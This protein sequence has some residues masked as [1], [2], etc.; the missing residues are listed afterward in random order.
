MRALPQ[1]YMLSSQRLAYERELLGTL[2][3]FRLEDSYFD[4]AEQF[5]AVGRLI[6]VAPRSGKREAFRV[7]LEYPRNFPGLPQ[8]VYD[9]DKRF[10]MGQ[11]GHLFDGHMLCLTLPERNE[12]SLGS[13]T[14]TEEVLGAA[15]IWFHKRSIF[16]R[17]KKWPGPAERHGRLAK[18][19]FL[20]EAAGLQDNPQALA[21]G[22]DLYERASGEAERVEIRLY[23]PCPCGSER[24]LKFCH[25]EQLRGMA[26]LLQEVARTRQYIEN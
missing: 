21:W 18:L 11:E 5:I 26:K 2:P 9:H 15:L 16:E 14:L 13:K 8:Q 10:Q 12:F 23:G 24:K 20:M 7:R 19:D 3:Y 22:Q 17:T 25:C 4:G 1:W 6:H